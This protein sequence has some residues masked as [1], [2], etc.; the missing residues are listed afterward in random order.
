[1]KIEILRADDPDYL[2]KTLLDESGQVRILPSSVIRVL[3]QDH[4]RLWLHKRG[5]YQL[6]TTELID[7][8]GDRIAGRKAIEIGSG[9]GAIGRALGIT[10]T[11]NFCQ[12]WPD[13]KL[14]Y[15]M[16]GQPTV[17][18]GRDVIRLAAAEALAIYRPQVVV[19]C[20]VTHLYREEE[21][22]RAGNTYGVDE[23]ALLDSGIETYVHVGATTSHDK[24]RILERAHEEFRFDW[25]CGRGK[26]QDRVIWVWETKR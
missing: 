15:A 5:V 20:W 13:V 9:N 19:A 18:Y 8:L 1:M 3:D 10:R 25:L 16:T 4:L 24:K 22:W 26:P 6:P 14:Q 11:D 2:D 17:G 12:T 23:E 21:N 7:W